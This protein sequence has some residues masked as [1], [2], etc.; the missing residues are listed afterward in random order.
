MPI[1]GAYYSWEDVVI[2]GPFGPIANIVNI[3]YSGEREVESVYGQGAAPRGAGRGNWKGEGKMTLKVEDYKLLLEYA[4]AAQKT[5]YTLAPFNISVSY[6][7]EDQGLVVDQLHRCRLQ[8]SSKKAA[9]GDKSLD[10]EL[11]FIFEELEEAGV[12]QTAGLNIL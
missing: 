1:N 5:I 3:E 9:Q 11:E 10:V 2:T 4:F 6:L 8:K 7:N 12:S